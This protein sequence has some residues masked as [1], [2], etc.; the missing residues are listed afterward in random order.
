MATAVR[1]PAIAAH[2]TAGIDPVILGAVLMP[3][4]TLAIWQRAI[5][6]SLASW[7]AQ[8]DLD[9]V[10]DL[11]FAC[12]IDDLA[13]A[14]VEAFAE[15][16]YP[17]TPGA[18]LLRADI[19]SLGQRFATVMDDRRVEIRLDVIETDACRKFHADAVTARLITT[20]SGPGTQWLD[21]DA[22]AQATA[23]APPATLA[24]NALAAG[25]VA[26]FKGRG[27]AGERAIIHRSP[28][29]AGSGTRRLVLVINPGDRPR[30]L[31]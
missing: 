5:A 20:Y 22:A 13:S 16:D 15:G 7:I 18:W 1:S 28:P 10:A 31:D 30:D 14:L 27:W 19:L 17:A 25:E 9:A 26:M 3:A 12:D 23:G 24:I 11:R 21:Q 4:I 2:V 6:D 8:L 29:I